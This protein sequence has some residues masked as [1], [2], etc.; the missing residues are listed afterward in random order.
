MWYFHAQ[1]LKVG[2]RTSSAEPGC[3]DQVD[4]TMLKAKSGATSAVQH[5]S[6]WCNAVFATEQ[7][8]RPVAVLDHVLIGDSP[9]R[10]RRRQAFL[11]LCFW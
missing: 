3:S 8:T 11:P 1:R 9:Q 5:M 4:A 7:Q 10:R 6:A 2:R